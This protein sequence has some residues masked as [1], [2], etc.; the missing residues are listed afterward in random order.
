MARFLA[1]ILGLAAMA[2][3]VILVIGPWTV[4]FTILFKACIPIILF[5]GGLV[6]LIAGVSS[7]KDAK[8]TK[9]LEDEIAE[10]PSEEE[11]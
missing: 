4:F 11:K 10:E 7:M 2:G 5:L 1:I 8:R 3:G 6:A 9:A